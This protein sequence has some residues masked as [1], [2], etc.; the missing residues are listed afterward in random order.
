MLDCFGDKW[1]GHNGFQPEYFTVVKKELQKLLPRTTLRAK[2]NIELK[3]HKGVSEMN[4]KAFPMFE[5]CQTLF[6]HDRD[7]GE[8]AKDAS[9][10]PNRTH[11]Q[12]PGLDDTWND[13]Y[14]PRYASGEPLFLDGIFVDVTG[15]DPISNVNPST[16]KGNVNPSTSRG[17]VNP[18]TSRGNANP[19]TPM[20]NILVLERP[21]GMQS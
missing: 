1:K 7:I 4:G 21:K 13:C 18:S 20:A 17:N 6:G 10:V 8:I 19:S 5:D 11:V 3:A 2:P 14:N 15:D 16:P 12:T 9:E